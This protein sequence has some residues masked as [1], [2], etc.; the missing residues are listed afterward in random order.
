MNND[1]QSK[2][3]KTTDL[4]SPTRRS[5]KKKLC[6][7]I[8]VFLKRGARA[9][10]TGQARTCAFQL[11]YCYGWPEL[12]SPPISLAR[13][14]LRKANCPR[15]M[16]RLVLKLFEWNRDGVV[17]RPGAAGAFFP[18]PNT[19]HHQIARWASFLCFWIQLCKLIT[20][21]CSSSIYPSNS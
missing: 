1:Y 16:H 3:N 19:W 17:T 13:S 11:D 14:L 10:N 21:S 18:K 2:I 6:W 8:K 15:C 4:A 12:F 20:S 7:G 5:E 9:E